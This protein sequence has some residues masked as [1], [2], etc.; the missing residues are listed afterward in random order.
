MVNA[1]CVINAKLIGV[2]YVMLVQSY[3]YF[4]Q[5]QSKRD[6][7][8]ERKEGVNPFFNL[9]GM[10]SGTDSQFDAFIAQGEHELK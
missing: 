2:L 9:G 7:K 6:K 5:I 1:V 10:G 8:N 3:R 4:L